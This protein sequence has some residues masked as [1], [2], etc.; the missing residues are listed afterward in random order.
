MNLC[1]TRRS[2]TKGFN[3]RTGKNRAGFTREDCSRG[4]SVCRGYETEEEHRQRQLI[5]AKGDVLKT[6]MSYTAEF[7]DGR[8][9]QKRRALIGRVNQIDVLLDGCV[10]LTTGESKLRGHN[11]FLRG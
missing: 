10:V 7:P 9:W 3:P 8:P 5:D 1:D 6:G 4:G 2:N 11:K